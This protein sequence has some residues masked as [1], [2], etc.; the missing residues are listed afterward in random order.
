M[1]LYQTHPLTQLF[2]CLRR[3]FMCFTRQ[4]TN[5]PRHWSGRDSVT[6]AEIQ[7]FSLHMNANIQR[8]HSDI[9]SALIAV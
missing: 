4:R 6:A 9:V 2:T 5:E 8:G 1:S 3:V 7:T